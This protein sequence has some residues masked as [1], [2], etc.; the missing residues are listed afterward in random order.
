MKTILT[1][2]FISALTLVF[3]VEINYNLSMPVPQNHYYH[4]EMEINDLKRSEIEVKM[5]VWAP[6]SYLVR[7]F[8]KSV[9]LVKAFDSKGKE[10]AIKKISKNTW[11]VQNPSKGNIK[12]KYEVYAFEL[13]VRTSFLDDSHGYFNGT[14]VFMYVGEHKD[15]TGNLNISLPKEFSKISTALKSEG[16]NSFSYENYDQLVDC[17]VEI[18]NHREFSFMAAGVNHRIAMYG[19]GNYDIE[20]LKKDITK[21][22]ES[23]TKV[24]AE[25]PNKEYLFIIHN[26]TQGGGGLE[27]RNS[28]TLQVNRWTY[29]GSAYVGFLSLVAH[30]Y[31]HLW[32]VKRLRPK[33]LGPFN[34][35]EENYTSLLWVMEGVTSYYD[36][37]ILRRAGF[38]TDEQYIQKIF[39]SMN[40]IENLEGFN[41]QPVAHA[42]FDAWIKSY[43]PNE[44]S[45]NTQIS[46]YTKGSVVAAL[47]DFMII[48]KYNGKKC[49]DDFLQVIYK[50]FY[51]KEDRGFT[52]FE[53]QKEL[54]AFMKEDLSMFFDEYIN[55]TEHIDYEKYFAYVGLLVQDQGE[56]MPNVGITARTKGG[57]TIVSRVRAGS[58]AD[59]QGINVDDEVIGLNGFRVDTESLNEA[60][61]SFKK[62]DVLEFVI[63][64][65][66][67]IKNVNIEVTERHN[68]VYRYGLNS[69]SKSSSRRDYWL[70]VD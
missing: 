1:T 38:Y 40:Y 22:V 13:S 26:L 65:D 45:S 50:K 14:S 19:V 16:G 7:E 33:E 18:G 25:N 11:K 36:E 28:T 12:I 8:A 27:H 46:Y 31:F 59:L 58:A 42:S 70:R 63:S 49:L 67:I 39:S 15:A 32:N 55:G 30:E 34:Y 69:D 60:M 64:R 37:L 9:N 35:D 44:N 10:L 48:K 52:E 51:K 29:Q 23:E 20:Q 47:I 53:F 5:P 41:V 66:N 54:E 2:L 43:R 4:I 62:G 3:G 61:R 57:K 68:Y 17:P 6:G 56:M 24:F 21:I